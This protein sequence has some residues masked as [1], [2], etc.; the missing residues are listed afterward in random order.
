MRR[1]LIIEPSLGL[2]PLCLF[3]LPNSPILISIIS[4][5]YAIIS[6]NPVCFLMKDRNGMDLDGR[7]DMEELR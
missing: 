6:S 5:Y 1:S 4:Y 3:V 2:F 7:R